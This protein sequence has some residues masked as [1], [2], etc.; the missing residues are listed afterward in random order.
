MKYV[1]HC[2]VFFSIKMLYMNYKTTLQIDRNRSEK[3][4]LFF[5]HIFARHIKNL[6]TQSYSSVTQP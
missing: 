5:V 1:M 4:N 2:L 3:K 6:Y